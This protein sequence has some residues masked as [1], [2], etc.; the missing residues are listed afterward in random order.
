VELT[1]E[2]VSPEFGLSS[3]RQIQACNEAIETDVTQSARSIAARAKREGRTFAGAEKI[4]RTPISKRGKRRVGEPNPRFA[5][6]DRELM[7]QAIEEW[8]AFE[9][10]H[11]EA[12]AKFRRG[13]R[14]ALFPY[15]TYGYK[16]VMGVR[17]S[18][19]A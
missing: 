9:W 3:R 2:P 11:A 17:V 19:S 14:K 4:L 1:I 13:Q 18:R 6:Q 15:G 8:R 10:A 12:A 7:E 16:R 5:T